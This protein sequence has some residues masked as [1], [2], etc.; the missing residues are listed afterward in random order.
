LIRKTTF[1]GRVGGMLRRFEVID[2]SS[3]R[4]AFPIIAAFLLFVTTPHAQT[5]KVTYVSDGDS[6][7]IESGERVRMIGMNAPELADKFG[8]ESKEHL[9]QLIRGKNVSLERDRLNEDRD[10]HGR[11][12]RYVSLDG[13]DINRQMIADGWAYAFLRYRFARDRRDAYRN[14]E[15]EARAAA[16]GVWAAESPQPQV[17]RSNVSPSP[18]PSRPSVCFGLV[19]LLFAAHVSWGRGNAKNSP[20]C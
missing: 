5:A 18:S 19:V 6:F 13:V 8:L 15:E 20:P 2:S 9:I 17:P 11:L 7:V 1:G 3:M 14:A 4:L 16:I 10:V 12:L